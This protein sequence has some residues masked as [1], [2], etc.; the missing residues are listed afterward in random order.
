MISQAVQ[1]S[2]FHL[3]TCLF[4][5][6]FFLFF[7]ESQCQKQLESNIQSKSKTEEDPAQSATEKASADTVPFA[8]SRS[9][10]LDQS[11]DAAEFIE[12]HDVWYENA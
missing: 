5:N 2:L 3:H 9:P 7:N 12:Q 8:L 1:G 10:F 6:I 11:W 4:N